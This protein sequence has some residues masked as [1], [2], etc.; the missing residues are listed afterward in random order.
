MDSQ[1]VYLGHYLG[2]DAEGAVQKVLE[3]LT[4]DGVFPTHHPAVW[5]PVEGVDVE[6]GIGIRRRS[7]CRPG[8]P[9]V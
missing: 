7:R 8:A 3:Y 2:L 5:M 1:P 6:R 4:D 9:M